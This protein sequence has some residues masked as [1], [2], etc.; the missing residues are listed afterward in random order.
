DRRP[1]QRFPC[2][3]RIDSARSPTSG[4]GYFGLSGRDWFNAVETKAGTG[5]VGLV[6]SGASDLGPPGDQ[7]EPR[8]VT[9]NPRPGRT[10]ASAAP[11]AASAW[12]ARR[13]AWSETLMSRSRGCLWL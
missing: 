8:I 7:P 12:R 10:R 2:S 9:I 1:P 3:D 4:V 11:A 6:V 5:T 13:A